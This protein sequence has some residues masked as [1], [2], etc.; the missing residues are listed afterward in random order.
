[1]N[2]PS[3]FVPT[4]FAM[5]GARG[6]ITLARQ[7]EFFARQVES[8]EVA[9]INQP[10]LAI[11]LAKALVET[12]CKTILNDHHCAL[13]ESWEMPRLIKETVGCL[14][15]VPDGMP[16]QADVELALRKTAGQLQGAV[17][18]ICEVRNKEG[19]ASHGRDGYSSTL[20]IIHAE[21]VARSADAIVSFLYKTHSKD[22]TTHRVPTY[23]DHA[24]VNEWI[25][26][27][28]EGISVIY[29]D[30]TC[31][32][33]PSEVMFYVDQPA[34]ISALNKYQDFLRETATESE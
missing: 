8:I 17:Q 18:G 34:Y 27:Q 3:D 33:S 12:T 20:D 15:L 30:E 29:G 21:F 5:H 6:V 32:C 31:E 7:P 2:S 4:G 9:V 13:E 28:N 11:D 25:D 16:N 26:E 22:Q 24:D 19:F 10:A 14:K 23:N 1:M